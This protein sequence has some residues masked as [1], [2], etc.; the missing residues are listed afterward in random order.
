MKNIDKIQFAIVP[1]RHLAT[2]V[3]FGL[4][5]VP[6]ISLKISLYGY[7]YTKKYRSKKPIFGAECLGRWPRGEI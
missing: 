7:F 1:A 6:K 5:S 2:L 4:H 3:A